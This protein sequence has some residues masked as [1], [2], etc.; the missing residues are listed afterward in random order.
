MH[1]EHPHHF[2]AVRID[3][4]R[5]SIEAIGTGET[6]YAACGALSK[7]DLNEK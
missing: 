6:E 5:P 1:N 7:I 4:N 2:V 3:G